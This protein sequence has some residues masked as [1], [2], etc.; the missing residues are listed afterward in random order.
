MWQM[1]VY[2]FT[3]SK[4]FNLEGLN[5]YYHTA[6]EE[7]D[8]SHLC[9]FGFFSFVMYRDHTHTFPSE[10]N[11]AGIMSWSSRLLWERHGSMDAK[12]KNGTCNP[13]DSLCAFREREY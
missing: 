3:A 5:P 10:K 13:P 6:G 11:V 1:K 12:S 4:K 7:G 2:N 9:V 8:I